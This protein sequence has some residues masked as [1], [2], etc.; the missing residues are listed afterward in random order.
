MK[1]LAT[2]SVLFYSLVGYTQDVQLLS[3][4]NK[5]SFRFTTILEKEINNKWD[6]FSLTE[7]EA[8]YKNADSL[9]FESNHFLNYKLIKNVTLTT[10]VGLQSDAILPQIGLGYTIEK[11]SWSYALYPMV[12]YA[13]ANKQFGSSLN[14][15]VEYTPA[16]NTN[17]NFY[18]LLLLD[19]DYD[20]GDALQ[21]QQYVNLGFLYNRKLNFGINID[22]MQ[23]NNYKESEVALGMFLGFNL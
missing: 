22:F 16:I 2:I 23:S 12:N 4:F 10:G 21:S 18:N 13:I 19:F 5:T 7:V 20:F 17:W 8:T 1:V 14:G 3:N 11:N 15:I 6:Y 9:S